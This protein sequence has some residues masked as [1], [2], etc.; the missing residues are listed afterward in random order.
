MAAARATAPT[1]PVCRHH[2]PLRR[3]A[4]GRLQREVQWEMARLNLFGPGAA[5]GGATQ[6]TFVTFDEFMRQIFAAAL[7]SQAAC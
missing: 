3:A 4:A 6:L 1:T 2:L 7:E 5:S